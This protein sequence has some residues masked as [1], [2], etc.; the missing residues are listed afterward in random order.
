M[1]SVGNIT[2]EITV[3]TK[4]S[5]GT[6]VLVQYFIKNMYINIFSLSLSLYL[7]LPF[8]LS[9]S[10]SVILSFA[11]LLIFDHKRWSCQNREIWSKL[12]LIKVEPKLWNP[13]NL[14][15]NRKIVKF[16]QR[17]K[18]LPMNWKIWLLVS[19]HLC[20]QIGG[21]LLF[22]INH[23]GYTLYSVGAAWAAE[24]YPALIEAKVL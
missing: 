24:K 18:I 9:P 15:Q 5:Q 20:K 2:L 12:C 6:K 16:S 11:S 13:V 1:A 10:P 3:N 19:Y 17:H 7:S 21:Y 4:N 22:A 8:P 23:Q 14:C